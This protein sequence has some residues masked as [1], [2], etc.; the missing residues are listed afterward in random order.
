[1]TRDASH[2]VSRAPR[3]RRM[4]RVLVPLLTLLLYCGAA[5]STNTPSPDDLFTQAVQAL[6]AGAYSEAIAEL[7]Q[8]SDRG[9]ATRNASYN[10]ALAY[11]LRAESPKHK[12][13]DLGQVVA[14]LREAQLMGDDDARLEALLNAVRTEISRQRARAGLD[15]VVVEPPLG[16]AVATLVPGD[17]WAALSALGSFTLTLGIIWF[18]RASDAPARLTGQVLCVVGLGLLVVFGGLCALSDHYRANSQE[19][20]VVSAEARLLSA[21]GEQLTQRALD[22]ESS[23]VPEGASVF[24]TRHAGRLAQV[25][26]GSF[27]AWV[28]TRHLRVLV[29][30]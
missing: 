24:V 6:E 2:P 20:I 3:R 7:E 22:V 25:N 16:R 30:H 18:R 13:G 17:V 8:L 14:A 27:D 23:A 28:E 26:W 4:P 1:M 29:S 19:A 5:S 10:R 21:S 9:V 11:L 12:P 15:P